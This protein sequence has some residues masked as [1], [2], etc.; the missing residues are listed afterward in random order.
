VSLVTEADQP[1]TRQA[2]TRCKLRSPRPF[3]VRRYK[4]KRESWRYSGSNWDLPQPILSRVGHW[5]Y[6]LCS[7][8]AYT[9]LRRRQAGP[10]WGG[11]A[12]LLHYAAY[13]GG[14]S[15]K[16][17]D[18]ESEESQIETVRRRG[19]SNSEALRVRVSA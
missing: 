18:I 19:L 16:N 2:S 6:Q 3:F 15:D 14:I 8:Q 4:R 12:D 10:A 17:P 13:E 11:G 7:A 5:H 9:R 1:S